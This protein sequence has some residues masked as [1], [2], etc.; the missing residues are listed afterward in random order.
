MSN[1][2]KPPTSQSGFL[3]SVIFLL[4]QFNCI[5]R[6]QISKAFCKHMKLA[7]KLITR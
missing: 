4:L 3:R 5:F 6:S 1:A 2:T 7:D